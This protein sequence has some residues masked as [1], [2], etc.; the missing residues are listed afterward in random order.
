MDATV[1]A[2]LA[3]VCLATGV[4]FGLAP[5]LQVSKTNLNEILKEGGRGNAGGRRARWLTS[6]MVVAE[7]ALTIVLLAGAGLMIRSFLKLYSLDDR[8][9]NRTPADDAHDAPGRQIQDRRHEAPVFYEA[10][11]PRLQAIPGVRA[12]A[13]ATSAPLAGGATSSLEVDGR[14]RARPGAPPGGHG[15]VSSAPATS[16]PWA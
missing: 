8:R 7:L 12:A 10:L 6:S 15:V 2:Y 3:A 14:A 11:L 4:L 9:R 1:F 5:A 13:I 16:T